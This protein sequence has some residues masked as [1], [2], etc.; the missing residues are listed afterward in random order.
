M[1]VKYPVTASVRTV[2][3]NGFELLTIVLAIVLPLAV[4]AFTALETDIS[5]WEIASFGLIGTLT[6]WYLCWFAFWLII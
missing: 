5:K 4:I 6:W 2:V 3:R 1:E